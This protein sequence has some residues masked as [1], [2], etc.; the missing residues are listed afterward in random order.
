MYSSYVMDFCPSQ[1]VATNKQQQ[2][3]VDFDPVYF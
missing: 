2:Q 3:T 1:N